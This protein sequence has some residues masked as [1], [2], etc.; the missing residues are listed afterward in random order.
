MWRKLVRTQLCMGVPPPPSLHSLMQTSET[1]KAHFPIRFLA[2]LYSE[3]QFVPWSCTHFSFSSSKGRL[4]AD[5]SSY[6]TQHGKL[7]ITDNLS[8]LWGTLIFHQG[9]VLCREIDLL[10]HPPLHLVRRSMSPNLRGKS[11][12]PPPPRP[13]CAARSVTSCAFARLC[14]QYEPEVRWGIGSARAHAAVITLHVEYLLQHNWLTDVNAVSVPRP[15]GSAS[16]SLGAGP[17]CEMCSAHVHAAPW[18]QGESGRRQ[19]VSH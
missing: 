11:P 18:K 14:V 5:K 19:A 1:K 6:F 8:L 4:S 16:A 10:K 13:F 15:A 17:E 7:N 2:F 12:P 9:S 3:S